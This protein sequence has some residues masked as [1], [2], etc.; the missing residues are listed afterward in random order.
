MEFDAGFDGVEDF[1]IVTGET[2]TVFGKFA[3]YFSGGRLWSIPNEASI[4][5][6][7]IVGLDPFF[8]GESELVAQLCVKHGVP[9]V[10]I[11]CPPESYMCRNASAVVIS[12]EYIRDKH[13]GE[14]LDVLF[15]RFASQASG[16]IV[17]TFGGNDIMYGR[18]GAK[19]AHMKPYRVEVKSTL[20]AGD[21]FRAGI[22]QGVLEGLGDA[23]TVKFAAATAACVCRQFPIGL[24]PPS[25][26]EILEL[27]QAQPR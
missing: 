2:R 12:H 4:A 24:H 3:Q 5:A 1:V 23:E 27:I 21:T 6:A 13:D 26:D 20:G 14:N 11:D 8:F 16:L 22:M 9:Y 18:K 10:T 25:M 15:E 19:A 17:F 7:K